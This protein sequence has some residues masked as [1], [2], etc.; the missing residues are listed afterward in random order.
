MFMWHDTT[1]RATRGTPEPH[2]AWGAMCDVLDGGDGRTSS[3]KP[4][5]M[6]LKV[7]KKRE[8]GY[9]LLCALYNLQNK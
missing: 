3:P 8:K 7:K 1:T 4:K 5:E 6:R 9:Y 2:A